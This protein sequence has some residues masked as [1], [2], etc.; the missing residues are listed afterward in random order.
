MKT[1]NIST[2]KVKSITFLF[3]LSI[4]FCYSQ[5]IQEFRGKVVNSDTNKKLALA[6]LMV[7]GT[8][9]S[10]VTNSEGDFLLKI[11]TEHINK[12]VMVSYIGY[13]KQ[14]IPISKFKK[15]NNKI[16]LTEAATVLAQIDVN[17]PKDAETLVRKALSLKGENYVNNEAVMTGFYRETIKKRNKNASL[18]EAVLKIYKQPYV[19]SKKDAITLVK[20]RK[21]TDYSRLDTLALKLQ[22]GPFSML[23]TDVMKYPEYIFTEDNLTNY[24]F[25]FDR[26]TQIDNKLVYVVNFKQKEEIITPLYYGQ[27]Y[28]DASTYALTSAIYNLN[29]E[30]RDLASKMFV[31]KKPRKADVYPTDAA[32][33]VNYRIKDGKWYFGYSNILLTFKINWKNKLFNSRYTLESEMAITDWDQN[34]TA[35]VN[36]PK[37]RLK[38]NTIMIDEAS[39]FSD[40]EFWGEYNIIE[41]EKSIE[42][43][44]KKISKQLKKA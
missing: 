5:N 39:G 29:V 36:R 1:L 9:I 11:P 33:R 28:I 13:K 22:G 34:T 37:D 26:S 10:T 4:C 17:V 35:F 15:N 20:S 19:S 6:N 16:E 38:P 23:Y 31:R 12:S 43:A 32:Y 27:L 7:V 44:I 25:N 24:T 40:P 3:L 42:S 2:I 21:N 14:E 41:P 30:D 8:N 18:S